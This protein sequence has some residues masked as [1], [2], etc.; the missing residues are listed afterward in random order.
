MTC[1][2]KIECHTPTAWRDKTLIR[3]W[4]NRIWV[5]PV[6]DQAWVGR[7]INAGYDIISG[8]VWVEWPSDQ[9]V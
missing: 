2:R 8:F 4:A 6:C 9:E 3:R 7:E 1:E 5:C